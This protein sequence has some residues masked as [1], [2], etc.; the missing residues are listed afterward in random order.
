[1]PEKSLGQRE[2]R[3]S[4]RQ[5]AAAASRLQG[6]FSHKGETSDSQLH[7]KADAITGLSVKFEETAALV[8]FATL[9]R[10]FMSPGSRIE[11]HQIIELVRN[12]ELLNQERLAD[13]DRVLRS[14]DTH[15]FDTL[16]VDEQTFSACEIYRIYGEGH[17]F[18]DDPEVSSL[19]AKLKQSPM[20]PV[21]QMLFYE[22]CQSYANMV[23][24]FLSE[25]IQIHNELLAVE[26]DTGIAPKCI[27]CLT[28]DGDFGPIEHVIP[29][30]W[31]IDELV[32]E[33][34]V[35]AE[36]NNSLSLLDEV[37]VKFE[38]LAFLRT[39]NV[40]LTKKGK[41]PR[42]DV[43]EVKIQKTKPREISFHSTSGK[44]VFAEELLP[45]GRVELTMSYRGSH[46]FN[47]VPLARSLF[48]IGLGLVALGAGLERACGSEF[49]AARNFVLN[50]GGFSNHLLITSKGVPNE[51][52]ICAWKDVGS[53]T[54]VVL[55]IF[56]VEFAFNL[57]P[58]PFGSPET[59]DA[60]L[61]QSLSLGRAGDGA[62]G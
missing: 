52:F 26:P 20:W 6:A 23:F 62:S 27:Y 45:N 25:V 48:K 59:I 40:P 18:G 38:P 35:C 56:G 16:V 37:L 17:L 7:I 19:V 53:T 22:V 39:V 21:V 8:R 30:A 10:R 46:A 55:N 2:L 54:I 51:S 29:E 61:V 32:L 4:L 47:P 33:R 28:K 31:G 42:A 60:S 24:M 44:P 11:L 57:Q 14:V 49:D 50:G 58:T 15:Q 12:S 34:A 1:V 41:F 9:L 36:C 13:L 5:F 43:G 3:E